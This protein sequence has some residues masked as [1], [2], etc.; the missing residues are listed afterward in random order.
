[1]STTATVPRVLGRRGPAT[2]PPHP[3]GGERGHAARRST[4]CVSLTVPPPAARA[5]FSEV[6]GGSTWWPPSASATAL[7]IAERARR[8]A[9]ARALGAERVRGDGVCTPR[10]AAAGSRPRSAGCSR[11]ARR[12]APGRLVVDDLLG[13]RLPEALDDPAD[14]LAVEEQRVDD[15]ARVVDRRVAQHLQDARWRA[16][17]STTAACAPDESVISELKRPLPAGRARRPAQPQ[18][19]RRT[20]PP[21]G[22][23]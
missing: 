21:R 6:Y 1:M 16:S 8:A 13:E 5:S 4:V 9:L 17:I 18:A 11:A 15:R 3:P 23:S 10:R 12:C 19:P 20:P 14:H 2:G 7:A 22:T